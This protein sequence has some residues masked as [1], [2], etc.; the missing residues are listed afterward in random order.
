MTH[1]PINRCIAPGPSREKAAEGSPA[2]QGSSTNVDRNVRNP[3][4]A[5]QHGFH[6]CNASALVPP[7]CTRVR[8]EVI[9]SR[10]RRQPKVRIDITTKVYCSGLAT[11]AGEYKAERPHTWMISTESFVVKSIIHR[12]VT[13]RHQ[14][15]RQKPQRAVRAHCPCNPATSSSYLQSKLTSIRSRKNPPTQCVSTHFSRSRSLPCHSPPACQPLLPRLQS[16]RDS[17]SLCARLSQCHSKRIPAA[18]SSALP[19]TTL[20]QNSRHLIQLHGRIHS[21]P[22]K[23]AKAATVP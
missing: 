4:V 8:E 7:D 11:V 1:N 3:T 22:I 17:I 15:C 20:A 5:L 12:P 19:T 18:S 21:L 14:D 10:W 9:P 6:S 13:L 16:L 23:P 2:I